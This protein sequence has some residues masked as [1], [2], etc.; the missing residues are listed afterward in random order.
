MAKRVIPKPEARPLLDETTK[1]WVFAGLIRNPDYFQRAAEAVRPEHF[2]EYEQWLS[3]VWSLVS[4]LYREQQKLPSKNLLC[5]RCNAALERDP[6]LLSDDQLRQLDEFIAMAYALKRKDWPE[7]QLL[8][9]LQQFLEDRLVSRALSSLSK[10]QTPLALSSVF[11]TFSEQAA[12][13]A[14]VVS[15]KLPKPFGDL[16]EAWH[17]EDRSSERITT[18]IQFLDELLDGGQR[19]G[20]SYGL[21]GPTGG[22]KTTLMVMIAVEAAKRGYQLWEAQGRQGEPPR[23]YHVSYEETPN[24]FRLRALSYAAGIPRS[25]LEACLTAHDFSTLSTPDRL[26]AYERTRYQRLLSSGQ[27]PPCEQARYARALAQLNECLRIL[28]HRGTVTEGESVIGHGLVDEIDARIRRDLTQHPGAYVLGIGADYVL[29]A[30]EMF[31]SWNKLDHGEL[32]HIINRWPMRM[33]QMASRFG[34]P[35]W[36]AQQLNTEANESR[37]GTVPKATQSSEGKAFPFNCDFCFV[38][39]VATADGRLPFTHAKH[40]RT[41]TAKPLVLQFRG[42]DCRLDDVSRDWV[43]NERTRTIESAAEARQLEETVAGPSPLDQG[44]SQAAQRVLRQ[45]L[46]T[47]DYALP[48]AT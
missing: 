46:R 6:R 25:R 14:A 48:E 38:V 8:E 40:R 33:R 24:D 2:T 5:L 39:G 4:Q 13:L 36:S 19:A 27:Q 37:P 7:D 45:Q 23:Y 35:V 26:Q 11:S 18:G 29:A 47:R 31:I 20:E 32:R 41:G 12:S 3:L 34:C 10:P 43:L 44:L 28:D 16:P 30:A 9:A 42:D 17:H 21:L 1:Q 15:S 22:G